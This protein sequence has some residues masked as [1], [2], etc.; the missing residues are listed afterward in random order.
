MSDWTSVGELVP[1]GIARDKSVAAQKAINAG[2][3]MDMVSDSYHESLA[4]QVK[5]GKVSQARLDDAVRNVLRVK[6]ALGLFED[7]FTDESREIQGALP[8]EHVEA[9]RLAAERSFVLLKNSIA[10]S[11][12]ILPLSV[13][14]GTIALIGP[15]GDSAQDMLGPWAGRGRAE[16]AV[17]LRAALEKRVGAGKVRYAKGGEPQKV[18]DEE[19]QAAVETAQQADVVLL[20]LGE[21]AAEQSGEAASRAH[22]DLPG[23][24][25]ELLEKVTATGKPVVLL[26]FSGRPLPLPWA[27]EHVPAVVAAWFP[28]IQ[29]GPALVRV[30]FG[31]VAP[32]GKLVVSWPRAMG[33]IPI[34][35]NALNTGRP[36]D[37]YDLTHPPGNS[38]EKF[39]SR[40]IDEQNTPLFPFGFGLTYS[41]LGYS[42]TELDSAK[43]KASAL[44]G[45]LRRDASGNATVTTASA[46]VKN[47]GNRAVDE[48]VQVYI[49]LIGTSVEEPVRKLVGFQRVSLAPGESK[50]VSFPLGADTF[51][52]WD[53][54]NNLR[55]EPSHVQ[56]WISPDSSRGLPAELEIVE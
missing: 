30:L 47:T 15:L 41:S 34:Y 39:V 43:L 20:A 5:H 19:I 23:R 22:L 56:V 32:S 10:G 17:T 21:G 36:A 1:H 24:Q 6:F 27:F 48:V 4:D 35:Y 49:R 25:E 40:Y 16:D 38:L 45:S 31:D 51:S 28:G 12:P 50:R 44:N 18:S 26:L 46:N 9:A 7:P 33:Q 54:Q 42:K 53:I 3:D 29:A 13:E 11:R 52:L 37:G 8:P 2:V 55:V 14:S